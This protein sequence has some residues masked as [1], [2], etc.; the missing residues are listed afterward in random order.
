VQGIRSNGGAL[1]AN[2]TNPLEAT[3]ES[4]GTDAM[5]FVTLGYGGSITLSFD[6]A[7]PNE[8]GAD[9]EVI[10]TSFGNP[11]C[12]AY[13]EYADV[14]VSQNGTD[15]FFAKTVCKSDNLVEIDLA[16]QGFTHV[17]YVKLVNND[18]LTT[19]PDGF[20]LDGVRAI[21]NCLPDGDDDGDD[22]AASLA[23]EAASILGSQPNPT[24]GLSAVFF[25]T[26]HT[27][28]T[29]LE[30]FDMSGRSVTTLFNQVAQEGQEYRMDFDGMSL[31]NGVY[32]YRLASEREVVI[33]KFMIAR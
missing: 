1:G 21:H 32:I 7:V 9:I 33:E 5:V 22:V 27:S 10:E 31:S 16:G 29:T 24:S 20:D 17:N 8:D 30:V 25:T 28:Y 13:Q 18:I 26:A 15:F 2:R 6:G 11:G 12:L 4:E 3:G 14:Y 19:T 23:T